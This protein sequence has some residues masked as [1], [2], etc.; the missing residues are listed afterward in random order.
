MLVNVNR[1]RNN[2]DDVLH[3]PT[4]P[5]EKILKHRDCWPT[6]FY[7]HKEGDHEPIFVDRMATL[8]E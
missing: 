2:I 7:M 3:S 5:E 8:G 6:A 1:L 4:L